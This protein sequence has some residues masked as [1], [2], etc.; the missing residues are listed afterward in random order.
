MAKAMPQVEVIWRKR[1]INNN[2]TH[3]RDAPGKVSF[4]ILELFAI[5]KI[6]AQL[7]YPHSNSKVAYVFRQR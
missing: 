3:S 7:R 2:M 6:T 4:V 1:Q 5:E